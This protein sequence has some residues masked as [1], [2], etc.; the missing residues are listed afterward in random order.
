MFHLVSWDSSGASIGRVSPGRSVKGTDH[1]NQE[2]E[3][4]SSDDWGS[5]MVSGEGEADDRCL[6]E[7][8]SGGRRRRV[9]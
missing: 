6:E 3:D 5:E 1:H 8:W 9:G 4:E 2:Q 7:F